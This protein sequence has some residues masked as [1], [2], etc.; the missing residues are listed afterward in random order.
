MLRPVAA[1][2]RLVLTAA[3]GRFLFVVFL[4]VVAGAGAAV[5]LL[6]AGWLVR[7]VVAGAQAG[8]L[9]GELSVAVVGLVGLTALLGFLAT[10]QREQNHLLGE[11]VRRYA[12]RRVLEAA[13]AAE[14]ADFDRPEFHDRLT[15][16]RYT[17]EV[18][19]LELAV[20]L[21]TT[22]GAIAGTAG[23]AVALVALNPLLAGLVLLSVVP[24]WFTTR[25][26]SRARYRFDYHM[27]SD[28]R[29][30]FYLGDLLTGKDEAKEVRAYG[31]G[32]MLLQRFH[33]LYDER[34]TAVRQLVR[35]RLKAA[36]V[37]SAGSAVAVGGVIA[38][39]VWLPLTDLS[40]AEVGVAVVSVALLV[41]RLATVT[42]GAATLYESALFMR[43]LMEFLPRRPN[44]GGTVSSLAGF[45]RLDL[46]DVRF[47]YPG[48][49]DDTLR[50]VSM[51][52][53]AG[54]IVALVGE[55]GSGKTTLAKLLAGL[56][57]PDSGAMTWDDVDVAG[58]DPE[59]LRQSVAITFQD[60]I[61]YRFTAAD[62]IAV[63][64]PSRHD[65]L[66]AIA[67][68]AERAGA[69]RALAGLPHG[70]ATRLGPEF[71]GGQ[72][73]SLGQWQRLALARA[74]F[75]DAPLVILDEP[76]ASLDPHAEH[77][78]FG[79]VRELCAG[80]TALII[81][82]RLAVAKDA[83]HIYVL[84]A[85][86]VVEEGDHESLMATGGRYAEMFEKQARPYRVTV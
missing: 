54:Q 30:R 18:R 4:Q 40:L 74:F 84:S 43:D 7:R 27:T 6:A 26:A 35:G 71:H 67:A 69:D 46:R 16:A 49:P 83:D 38:A 61:R 20:G 37:G 39:A 51:S 70:Y 2:I 3:R 81:S 68:A 5:Q 62:N 79:N 59:A 24:L 75:R 47:R 86:R 42:T 12:V 32:P 19:P 11:L 36:L 31:L 66:D 28:D 1:A 65:D 15:R 13:A 10:V 64:R 76:T 21:V 14:L 73:L 77:A 52:I 33:S 72:D 80:R 45:D 56:Y 9:T 8:A 58:L 22:S 78:L 44:P 41:P 82:H 55:N 50:G 85:G 63:G 29:E 57:R 25:Y 53:R 60:F 34:I 23:M 48:R 17:A